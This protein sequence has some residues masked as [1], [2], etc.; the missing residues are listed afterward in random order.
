M[1]TAQDRA[2][3]WRPG[4]GWCDKTDVAQVFIWVFLGGRET[5]AH[6]PAC[7]AGGQAPPLPLP[8]PAQAEASGFSTPA[9]VPAVRPCD[10]A[11]AG[12]ALFIDTPSVSL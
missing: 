10:A 7:G 12:R 2:A 3:T 4:T 6:S 8:P 5:T 11:A 9:H 1:V